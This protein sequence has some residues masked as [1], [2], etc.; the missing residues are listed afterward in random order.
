[1]FLPAGSAYHKSGTGI[2]NGLAKSDFTWDLLVKLVTN[3]EAEPIMKN[4]K[5]LNL[6]AEHKAKLD[7]IFYTPYACKQVFDQATLLENVS[8][9][10]LLLLTDDGSKCEECITMVGHHVIQPEAPKKNL[11]DDKSSTII[12]IKEEPMTMIKTENIKMIKEIDLAGFNPKKVR[13][14]CCSCYNIDGYH[15]LDDVFRDHGL[16]TH[17]LKRTPI[18][19]EQ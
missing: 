2:A 16:W 12:P 10:L 8:P 7:N 4:E 18:K 1:M 9:D 15:T 5:S 6:L 11:V 13:E 14:Y 19:K 3:A 17:V